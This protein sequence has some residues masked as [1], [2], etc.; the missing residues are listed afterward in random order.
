MVLLLKVKINNNHSHKYKNPKCLLKT[1][2][3]FLKNYRNFLKKGPKTSS[4][5]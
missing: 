1:Q 2:I 5:S 3:C 4:K